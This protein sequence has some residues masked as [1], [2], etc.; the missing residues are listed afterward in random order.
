MPSPQRGACHRDVERFMKH[1]QLT[2]AQKINDNADFPVYGIVTDGIR[3]EFG[4]LV[5]DTFTQ[6]RT[7]FD[8]DNLPMLFGAVNAV[9]KAA[10]GVA[11]K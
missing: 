8:L 1:P 10:T 7:R 6:N 3:W 11:I 9:F 4:Q 2:A 5:G